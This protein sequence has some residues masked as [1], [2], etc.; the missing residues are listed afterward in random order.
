MYKTNSSIVTNNLVKSFIKIMTTIMNLP[1]P[2]PVICM[3]WTQGKIHHLPNLSMFAFKSVPRNTFVED[4]VLPLWDQAGHCWLA[5]AR[6]TWWESFRLYTGRA[7]DGDALYFGGG[8][9]CTQERDWRRRHCCLYTGRISDVDALSFA[10][11][12]QFVYRVDLQ[13]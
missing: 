7:F 9:V 2:H 11:T 13:T 4:S 8:E 12:L 1:D 5:S 10:K 6:W 3:G